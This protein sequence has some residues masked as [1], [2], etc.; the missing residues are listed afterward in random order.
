LSPNENANLRLDPASS[1]PDI[2][3][4]LLEDYGG[5][6]YSLRTRQARQLNPYKFDK[7][8]YKRQLRG[9]PEAIV[10]ITSPRRKGHHEDWNDDNVVQETQDDEWKEPDGEQEDEE[11]QEQPRHRQRRPS[12]AEEHPQSRWLLPELNFKDDELPPVPLLLG[13]TVQKKPEN[14]S[15]HSE[16]RKQSKKPLKFPLQVQQKD[17]TKGHPTKV[18]IRPF[19]HCVTHALL[20]A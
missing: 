20:G 5:R 18:S 12:N 14:T 4:E 13:S 8:M 7:H 17:R 10:K 1:A 11:S 3:P 6:R 16:K 9:I 15:K 19:F 2:P